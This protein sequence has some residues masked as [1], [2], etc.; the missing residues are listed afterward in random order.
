MSVLLS[1]ILPISNPGDYK[2]HLSSWNQF[3]QPLDVFVRD[4]AEWDSWNGWMSSRDDFNRKYILSFANFYHETNTWLFAGIYEVMNRR[5]EKHSHAYDVKRLNDYESLVGRIKVHFV[6]PGRLRSI[7]LERYFDQMIVSE[8]LKERYTGERFPGYESI[9]Y[10]FGTLEAIFK[11][12][13]PDWRAAL[14]NVKGIYL[15]SDKSN[16]KKYVGSAYGSLGIWSRW[17]NYI[18]TGH[19]ANDELSA[20]INREGLDYARQ[21]FRICLLEY[22]PFNTPDT[23]VIE[24]ECYWKEA[25]L[26]RSH[27]YN[28]N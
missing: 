22:R 13:R 1:T 16:G 15:I 28:K 11:A 10:D 12:Q 6:R 21:N 27:G 9:N 17:E 19:G 3:D 14:E 2:V 25:L 4:Q 20:L 23:V 26:S 7:T 8:L 5:F 24:R 18:Y